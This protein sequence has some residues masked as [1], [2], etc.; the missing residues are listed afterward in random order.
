[1]L[2]RQREILHFNW[3]DDLVFDTWMADLLS[4]EKIQEVVID[5]DNE[6]DDEVHIVDTSTP[7]LREKESGNNQ[8]VPDVET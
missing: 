5:E 6:Q 4:N 8:S 1:M 3:P 2:E 7:V